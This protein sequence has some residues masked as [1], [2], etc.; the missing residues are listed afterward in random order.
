MHVCQPFDDGRIAVITKMHH[1]LADGVAANALLGNIVDGLGGDPR[2]ARDRPRPR[3]DARADAD[4]VRPAAAGAGRRDAADRPAARACVSRTVRRSPRCCATGGR[5]PISVPRP[6]LDVPHTPFNGAL[7]ARRNFATATLADRRDQ[8]GAARPR[9][10]H[11]RR[12]AGRRGRRAAPLAAG[13]GRAARRA[14]WWPGCRWPPT[15]PGPG[16]ASAATGSPTC[17]P[18]WPPTSRTRTSGCRRSRGSPASPS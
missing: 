17:S 8:G 16:R 11:E 2:P 10:D 13:A 4:L 15:S 14:R 1:A 18:R 6:L 12:R 9:R 3:C 7:T 5:R